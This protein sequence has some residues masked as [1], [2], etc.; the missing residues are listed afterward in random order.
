MTTMNVFPIIEEEYVK[1]MFAEGKISLSYVDVG[2][3]Q[4]LED[5][6]LLVDMNIAYR[7]DDFLVLI[8]DQSLEHLRT[9]QWLDLA[10]VS[11]MGWYSQTTH[12]VK[13]RLFRGIDP[14]KFGNLLTANPQLRFSCFELLRDK[15][16]LLRQINVLAGGIGLCYYQFREHYDSLFSKLE[17]FDN[18]WCLP[19]ARIDATNDL[20]ILAQL[21]LLDGGAQKSLQEKVFASN[22]LYHTLQ[23]FLASSFRFFVSERYTPDTFLQSIKTDVDRHPELKEVADAFQALYDKYVKKGIA[24]YDQGPLTAPLK[25]FLDLAKNDI[26]E[27][28]VALSNSPGVSKTS[29]FLLGMLHTAAHLEKQFAF[30]NFIPAVAEILCTGIDHIALTKDDIEIYYRLPTSEDAKSGKLFYLNQYFTELRNISELRGTTTLL[31]ELHNKK[32]L[33][34]TIR[35]LDREIEAIAPGVETREFALATK[36]Q[37]RELSADLEEK[38]AHIRILEGD[39][40]ALHGSHDEIRVEM[41]RKNLDILN[42]RETIRGLGSELESRGESIKRLEGEIQRNGETIAQMRVSVAER[43]HKLSLVEDQLASANGRFASL[44]E[45]YAELLGRFVKLTSLYEALYRQN[46]SVRKFYLRI[47]KPKEF[48]RQLRSGLQGVLEPLKVNKSVT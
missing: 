15:Q 6:K 43:D 32:R 30:T 26:Q 10:Q 8:D 36:H 37:N 25:M 38:Q 34:D 1:Q 9:Q 13:E 2:R 28:P 23:I 18:R 33:E 42:Q 22:P 17:I 16:R 21:M 12:N 27:L 7:H 35:L 46:F 29:V 19:R 24:V 31:R 45:D 20:A 11:Q 3:Q 39:L 40:K 47:L 4:R 14:Q 41:E 48:E 5:F 44:Q